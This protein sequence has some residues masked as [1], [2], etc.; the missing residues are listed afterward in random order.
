MIMRAMEDLH[1]DLSRSYIIGDMVKDLQAGHNAGVK[2]AILVKTG[3]GENVVEA[4]IATYVA[5]N[6]LDAVKWIMKDRRQ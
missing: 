4:G 2:K 3:Y 6:I 5:D 1:L